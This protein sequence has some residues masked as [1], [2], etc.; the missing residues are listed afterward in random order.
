M[1]QK[2]KNRRFMKHTK[3]ALMLAAAAGI[4]MPLF[5]D[6]PTD[7][8]LLEALGWMQGHQTQHSMQQMVD[9]GFLSAEE[10]AIVKENFVKGLNDKDESGHD[11]MEALMPK[12]QE[13]FQKRQEAVSKKAEAQAA[14]FFEELDKKEGIQQTASGLR[15]EIIE[16]GS[17]QKPAATD[18][19]KVHY[20]GK[21]VDG[22]VF[23]SSIERGEPIE[24]PLSGVI[25]GWTEGLQ[26]IGKGGKVKLYIP[27]HLAY[28]ERGM[29]PVIPPNATLIFDVELLDIP[30]AAAAPAEK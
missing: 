25:A 26:L 1:A 2:P 10:L 16:K 24:F 15:Y 17:D 7:A 28:G 11:K 27:G 14:S 12:L 9:E 20:E 8:Q 5:G 18:T 29:P 21:L 22:K 6:E 4:A 30:P 19:V 3:I 23:D 13:F